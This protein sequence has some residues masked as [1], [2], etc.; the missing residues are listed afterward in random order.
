MAAYR[1]MSCVAP[2][3]TLVAVPY[4]IRLVAEYDSVT[5]P[6]EQVTYL[7]VISQEPAL[8]VVQR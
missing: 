5:P 7:T 8:A 6:T 1:V 3:G 4:T 2:D